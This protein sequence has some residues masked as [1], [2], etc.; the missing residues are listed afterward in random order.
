MQAAY[1]LVERA[2]LHNCSVLILGETGT[3]KELLARSIHFSGPRRDKP[4]VPVDCSS[5]VPTLIEAELFGFIKGA[6]TDA[7]C[8]QQGLMALANHGTF[9]LDEIGEL[10][11]D[12]Q[13]KLLRALQEKEV[14][15]VGS[16]ER[17]PI[18]VRVVAATNRDLMEALR[19]GT[20]RQDLYFRLNVVEIRLPP[21]RERKSD[22]PL[23]ARYFIE[24]HRDNNRAVS[25]VSDDALHQ[26]MVYEWP[27]NVRELEN[28]IES[29]MAL[30]PGTVI[31]PHDLPVVVQEAYI[32]P[33]RLGQDTWS[34]R[35]LKRRAVFRALSKTGG[36]KMA[37]A[38]LLKISKT[39]LYRWLHEERAGRSRT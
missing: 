38:R 32:K 4:F 2:S 6:F 17:I 35:E 14:K 9:F 10:P 16:N 28:A 27:G 15:P 5:L 21:L 30:T 36:D 34:L 39:T 1:R 11:V 3:G 20:F 8:N 24:K 33:R 26:L 29:A 19:E 25:S 23:L 22:I 7:N 13:S 12:L 18:D 31:E 37:A